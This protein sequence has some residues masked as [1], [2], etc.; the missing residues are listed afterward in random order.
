[1]TAVRP[2]RVVLLLV[3]EGG[4]GQDVFA[5]RLQLLVVS[6]NMLVVVALPDRRA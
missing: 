6:N 4:I 5:D 2:E 1:M 3:P